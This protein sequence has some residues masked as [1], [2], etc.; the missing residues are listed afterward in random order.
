MQYQ[1]LHYMFHI[2]TEKTDTLYALS[3]GRFSAFQCIKKWQDVAAAQRTGQL[4][5]SDSAPQRLTR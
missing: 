4:I 5:R 2:R 1:I 3:T